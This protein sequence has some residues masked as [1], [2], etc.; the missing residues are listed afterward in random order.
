MSEAIVGPDVCFFKLFRELVGAAVVVVVVSNGE[1][2]GS[3][4]SGHDESN[5]QRMAFHF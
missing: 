3:I 2:G 1:T 5:K 4:T